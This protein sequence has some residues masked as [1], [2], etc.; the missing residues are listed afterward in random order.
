MLSTFRPKALFNYRQFYLIL[1]TLPIM[2]STPSLRMLKISPAPLPSDMPSG[3]L[4]AMLKH[5]ISLK[6]KSDVPSQKLIDPHAYPKNCLPYISII[7]IE[8]KTHKYK[9]RLAGS[10]ICNAFGVNPTG[11][12]IS[13]LASKKSNAVERLDWCVNQRQHYLATD[14]FVRGGLKRRQYTSLSLPYENDDGEIS[15]ILS[16]FIF[17]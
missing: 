9:T 12:Y 17:E 1:L 11:L 14:K 3:M 16:A 10:A 13:D 5:W 15:R 8:E 6:G 2:N 4:K 7:E